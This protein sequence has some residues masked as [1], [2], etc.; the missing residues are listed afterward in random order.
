MD[1]RFDIYCRSEKFFSATLFSGILLK[2]DFEGLRHF[3]RFLFQKEIISDI[4]QNDILLEF[5]ER[6][7]HF[8]TEVNLYRDFNSYKIKLNP[9]VYQNK[10]KESTP[11]IVFVYGKYVFVFE[12]KVY[13]SYSKSTIEEQLNCQRYL[14]DMLYDFYEIPDMQHYHIAILPDEISINNGF[15]ISWIELYKYFYEEIKFLHKN[16]FIKNILEANF[17]YIYR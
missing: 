7:V 16:D 8:A 2:N 9:K 10:D 5:D 4:V 13:T 12:C 15:V 6:K 1:K 17:K 11:D 3:I 14:I